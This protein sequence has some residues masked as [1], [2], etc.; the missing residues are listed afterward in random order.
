MENSKSVYNA[1]KENSIFAVKLRGL[2]EETKRTQQ[3]LID[4]IQIKTGKAPTRQAVSAWTHGNSPDI[5]TVPIIAEFF[6]VSTDYLLTETQIRPID[7]ELSAVCDYTGLSPKSIE[8]IKFISQSGW[9][10]N[11]LLESGYFGALVHVLTNIDE[12]TS[13]LNYYNQVIVPAIDENISS[14]EESEEQTEKLAHIFDVL[15]SEFRYIVDSQID[16][17]DII[18]YRDC[19]YIDK[20]DLYEFKLSKVLK[21]MVDEIKAEHKADKMI[22]ELSNKSVYDGLN[23]RK[24][25]IEKLLQVYETGM[26]VGD[27]SAKAI[28]KTVE[29]YKLQL[30]AINTIIENYDEFFKPKKEG[31]SNV[32]HNQKQE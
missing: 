22:F 10:A 16:S 7:V 24:E 4:F 27:K 19:K 17:D 5:K 12:W 18:Q 6:K 26:N 20:I 25:K 3:E 15:Y 13:K 1:D 32:Q 30:N 8:N 23:T 31:V 11:I 28:A 29:K 21:S 14:D 9:S 2:F